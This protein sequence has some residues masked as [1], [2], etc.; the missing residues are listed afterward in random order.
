VCGIAG[1]AGPGESG[2]I[3][4]M[5]AALAHRG[6]DG[7]GFLEDAAQAVFLGHR[8][9]SIIDIA[10]G[11]Q[12]FFNED[13]RVAV[14]FNGEIYNHAELRAELEARGHRF[15]SHHSDTEVLVHGYEEWGE[16]LP[17][18]LSGM[19]AFAVYDAVRRTLFLARDRFGE[20]PLY[21]SQQNG[22]FAFASEASALARHSGL[23][24]SL[25]PRGLQKF[26]AHGFTPAPNTIYRECRKLPAGHMLAFD[27]VSRTATVRCY[28]RFQLEPDDRLTATDEPRLAEELR[29]LLLQAVHRRLISD[30]PLGLFLSGGIDSSSVA[31]CAVHGRPAESLDTFAIGFTDPS[32]DESGFAREA[33]RHYGFRHHEEVLEPDAARRLIGPVLS[34]LDEPLG[35]ASILPT[36]LLSRFTRRSVT[37]ALTGDGGDEMFAGYDPFKALLPARLYHRVARGG[38]HRAVRR[39]ADLLPISRANMS[40]DFKLKR[41]LGGVSYP[42]P[43]WNPVWLAPVEP[44][45]MAEL[46]NETVALDDVY[47]EVLES[48]AANPKAGLV[49][50]TLDF[51]TRFYLQDDILMKVDRAAMMNGLETRAAFLDNDL[52]AFCQRLPTSF[53]FARGRGKRLLRRAMRG[54]V[55]DWI[56]ERP[57]KGFGIPVSKWLREWP[58]PQSVDLPGMRQGAFAHLWHEHAA[59]VRDNRL[60][61]W[62]CLSLQHLPDLIRAGG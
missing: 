42:E 19:F 58:A 40:F 53:K 45:D 23:H 26:F 56:L 1:F 30:V 31:A 2:D 28:W 27:L 41:F 16:G 22:I 59:G 11:D 12:P 4:R 57:K 8:R 6:P 14:V 33:A 10:G 25:D 51:Y 54:M 50:R 55:P 39:L 61:I 20:K 44:R 37:V 48:W 9:L 15:E 32:F 29:A 43:F 35:D 46:L 52:A 21:Y 34:G 60:P 47:S 24:F 36:Y 3:R 7:E 62:C 18:R 38:L 5:T 13:G 49:E 17:L